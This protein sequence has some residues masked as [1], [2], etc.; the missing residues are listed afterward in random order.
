MFIIKIKAF[1][2][3]SLHLGLSPRGYSIYQYFGFVIGM[4]GMQPVP[5][6]TSL[7]Q[8]KCLLGHLPFQSANCIVVFHQG[9]S[10]AVQ[11]VSNSSY[12]ES[13]FF[14]TNT[15]KRVCMEIQIALLSEWCQSARYLRFVYN[16]VWLRGFQ[17][18]VWFRQHDY[19]HEFPLQRDEFLFS[20]GI[21]DCF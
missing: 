21:I 5:H 2:C 19:L 16:P 9:T 8:F 11:M 4:F 18:L 13:K 17:L 14:Y 20:N 12:K 7:L 15:H 6:S 10:P 3:V 1:F